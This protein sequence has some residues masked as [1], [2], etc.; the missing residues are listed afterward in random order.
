MDTSWKERIKE[1]VEEMNK[2][3]L[4]GNG[5]RL[6]RFYADETVRRKEL[7]RWRREREQYRR[8]G[9]HPLAVKTTAVPLLTAVFADSEVEAALSL[10]QQTRYMLGEAV[11]VQENRRIQRVRMRRTGNEWTFLTPW[12]WF[13]D[14]RGKAVPSD[15]AD[16]DPSTPDPSGEEPDQP[17]QPAVYGG[18]YDRLRAVAYAERYWNS[19][20]P[21]YPYLEVDCTN[22]VSQCLHAGGIPMLFTGSRSSGWWYRGRNEGWSY[23]WMVAHS[24]YLLLR[25]GKAPMY[26]KQ[27]AH[28]SLLEIG[29]VI[30]YDFDGDGR[31]QH[32]TIVVAKDSQ[33][34]P[35]VN[36]H[37]TN[38]RMRYWEYRDSSAYT[39][40]IRY[41]FFHIMG[42][43]G[44]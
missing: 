2:S 15:A 3:Y 12:G 43:S 40:K 19:P 29:D 30:C 23:S 5:E 13:F 20:N 41:A 14:Q 6:S 42:G 37:T 18:G 8:R 24:L 33:N 34:M 9:A 32:N 28:P 26:A 4:D 21:A 17:I 10:H 38:S 16:P 27:V 31:W 39:S 1:Y 7:E 11:F 25:S 36:A 44:R 22:F 35:L